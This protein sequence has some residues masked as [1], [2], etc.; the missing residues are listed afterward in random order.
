MTNG[1]RRMALLVGTVA[2]AAA[3]IAAT[4]TS[5]IAAP[6]PPPVK[7]FVVGGEDTTTEENPFAVA[8]LSAGGQFCGGTL[9]A[10]NKVVTAA[11]C[12]VDIKDKPEQVQV[13]I[14]RTKMS[15][16][17]GK[18]FKVKAI[19]VHEQ[20][21][22]GK[23]TADVSVLTLES[24]TDAKPMELAGK[25]DEG[26]QPGAEA[27]ALGWGLTSENGEQS[28]N[29]KKVSL[30]VVSDDGCKTAYPDG[31]VAEAHVCAGVEEGGKDTCQGDSGGPL[32]GSGGKLIGVVSWG[33]GCAQAGKYGVYSRVSTYLDD[34]K[35]QLDGGTD[36]P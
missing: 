31:Y 23:T 35:K 10:K 2:V 1:S 30:P 4:A 13:A 27:V 6:P 8:L 7:P 36:T 33:E 11:H 9:A 14:G 25:S 34:I 5:A 3:S 19:W 28:D 12:T 18:V 21:D 16:E 29:L 24:D 26:Y 17:E 15:S 32:V 20:Y 22:A